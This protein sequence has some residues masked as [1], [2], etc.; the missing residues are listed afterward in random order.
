MASWFIDEYHQ[1]RSERS[2]QSRKDLLSGN[3]IS[4]IVAGRYVYIPSRLKIHSPSSSAC[5]HNHDVGASK[6]TNHSTSDTTRAS[7]ISLWYFLCKHPQHADLIL[8][9]LRANRLDETDANTLANT[10]AKLSHLNAVI[11]ET[12]RLVPPQLTGGGRITPPEGLWLNDTWIPGGTKVTAPKYVLS[13]RRFLPL[14][15]SPD[16]DQ[17]KTSSPLADHTSFFFMK[18][19]SLNRIPASRLL[20]PRTLD[21]ASGPHPRR[22][23]LCS[24][25][26]WSVFSVPP[27]CP[28]NYPPN[29]PP[30]QPLISRTGPRQCV[31]KN[32]AILELRFVTVILLKRFRVGFAIGYDENALM[33]DL[34]DQVTAQPGVCWCVFEERGGGGRA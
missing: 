3:A 24:F 5:S 34:R 28:P 17:N 32:L 14:F 7:L 16:S 21:L 22:T 26:S 33:R 11:N 12:L 1:L 6:L 2:S 29:L 19:S 20:H 10:L 25:H 31:G 30:N 15:H 9:E 23:S 27:L 8:S 13:R 4:A 18:L